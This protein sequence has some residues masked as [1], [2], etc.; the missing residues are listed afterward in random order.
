MTELTT[1]DK[2]TNWLGLIIGLLISL[3]AVVLLARQVNPND[4]LRALR[5]V[6]F[7][8]LPLVLL[9]FF[10]T[11]AAR[12][13]AWR[14]LLQ[15]QI[16][17]WKSFLTINEGYLFNNVLPF[18]LGEVA[19]AFLLSQ[20]TTIPFWEAFSTVIVERVFDMALLAVLLLCTVPFVIGAQWAMQFA[21]VATM[22]VLAGF[23]IMFLAARNQ[24]KTLRLFE[25]I[26]QPWPK[27]T[28]W[29]Y[30][31]FRS[32]LAGLQVLRQPQCFAK[33][34]FW[35]VLTWLFNLTWYTI[36]LRAFVTQAQFLWAAFAVAVGSM[37]VSLPSSPGYIG[38]F[39]AAQVVALSIFGLDESLILA[40]A[41]FAHSLYLII[42]IAVG[43]YALIRDGQSLA[44]VYRGIRNTPRH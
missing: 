43:A 21:L 2:K 35:M 37:G 22:L 42:T 25:A 33:V 27:L 24:E 15:R 32:L 44:Q 8:Y 1:P 12:A 7:S 38:V 10:C 13:C 19:R 11:L 14:E 40:Y 18:R 5:L 29:G 3:I 28:K 16:S 30:E 6:N 17:W 39:E 41:V 9:F 36:L 34:L 20:T 4:M 26:T 23:I 31:K